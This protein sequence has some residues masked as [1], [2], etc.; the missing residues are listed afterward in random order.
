MCKSSDLII[1]IFET[2]TDTLGKDANNINN[3]LKLNKI[4]VIHSKLLLNRHFNEMNKKI[5]NYHNF[6]IANRLLGLLESLD[7]NNDILNRNI[8]NNIIKYYKSLY[9]AS[10][11]EKE[12]TSINEKLS[13]LI[14]KLSSEPKYHK[15]YINLFMFLFDKYDSYSSADLVKLLNEFKDDVIKRLINIDRFIYKSLIEY[16]KKIYGYE[17][18]F[19]HKLL[20]DIIL[21]F[22]SK[23]HLLNNNDIAKEFI[24]YVRKLSN[25]YFSS[26]SIL[27]INISLFFDHL[28]QYYSH[29]ILLQLV[30]KSNDDE[31]IKL[32]KL[33]GRIRTL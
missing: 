22:I 11:D 5:Y 13:S 4:Q 28:A 14:E 16:Y 30:N 21:S 10:N 27:N 19:E 32:F 18:I 26:N 24:D 2:I 23:Y 8:C 15:S 9:V 20:I 12:K 29:N 33:F 17:Y 7:N 31:L 25:D 6:E 1:N 3:I